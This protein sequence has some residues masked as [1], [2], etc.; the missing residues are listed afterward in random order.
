M[1][2]AQ[3][4]EKIYDRHKNMLYRIAFTFL[5]N[6]ADVEDV[7]QEVFL[8]RLYHAPKFKDEEHE[9][10][11]LI[12]ITVNLS[13]DFLKSFWHNHVRST[14]VTIETMELSRWNFTE[15]QKDIYQEV[16]SLPEKQR[17]AIYLHYY[18]GYSCKEISNI[19]KCSE[20][21]VKMRLKRGRELMRDNMCKEGFICS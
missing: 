6:D 9:K 11:W 17:A 15:R 18:E 13:K 5:K 8:K 19:L 1:M 3:D 20:S 14:D 4:F 10:S 16:V 12:R 2:S 21:A 7:L